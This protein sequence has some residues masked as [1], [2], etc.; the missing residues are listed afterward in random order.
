MGSV[1]L[2]IPHQENA[3]RITEILARHDYMPDAVCTLGSE[4]LRTAG[5]LDYGI[6]ICAKKLRDMNYRELYEYLPEHFQML[7]I[8][9]NEDDYRPRD[10]LIRL[11]VPFRASDLLNSLEMMM[12]SLDRMVKRNHKPA[13]SMEEKKTIDKAKLL[14]MDRN[15]MTEPE[16]FRYIQKTSM[17]TGRTMIETAEMILMLNCEC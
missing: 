15:D 16:A 3:R 5:S 9:S 6:V 11:S 13:R 12:S 2:A 17:D 14:L 1:I 8:S 7:L 10:G 4:V